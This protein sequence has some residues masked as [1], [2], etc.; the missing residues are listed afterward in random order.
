M[1]VLRRAVL[2]TVGSAEFAVGYMFY[3]RPHLALTVLGRPVLDT[4]ISRQYGL[5]IA[6]VALMYG[7][8]ALNPVD[9]RRF[10]WIAV[11]QRAAELSVAVIDWRA[12]ALP[13][14]SFAYLAI[15]EAG[16]AGILAL[17]RPATNRRERNA[18]G[19]RHPTSGSRGRSTLSA[20]CS[21]SGLFSR[22]FSCN[23]APVFSGGNC[24]TPI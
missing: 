5:F 14:S 4:V 1:L 8:V 12:G 2:A 15:V 6:S 24:R 13:A 23:S 16:V 11:A 20:A 9:Y 3:F 21:C 17:A 10:I 18:A 19:T 7:I 22:Q